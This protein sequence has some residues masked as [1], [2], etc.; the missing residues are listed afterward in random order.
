MAPLGLLHFSSSLVAL[1]AGAV[2]LLLTKGGTWHRRMGWTYVGSMLVLNLTALGIYRLTRT[3]GPFH[4]AAIVSLIGVVAGVIPARRRLPKGQWLDR[5]Y[6]F[7]TWSYV[8]LVAAA[9]SET[10]TRFPAVRAAAGGPGPAFWLAVAVATCLVV[11]TGGLL[12]SRRS[13]AVLAPHRGRG[14]PSRTDTRP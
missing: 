2:V 4:F 6:R 14:A 3:F 12:I 7:M 8:G 1:L 10:A 11:T 5:H 13:R 9:V